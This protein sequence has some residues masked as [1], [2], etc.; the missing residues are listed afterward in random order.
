MLGLDC[1]PEWQRAAALYLRLSRA[2]ECAMTKDYRVIRTP[3]RPSDVS[4][5]LRAAIQT[6][7]RKE[8]AHA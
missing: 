4:A 8:T 7:I 5:W 2:A 3:A 6:A 1:R